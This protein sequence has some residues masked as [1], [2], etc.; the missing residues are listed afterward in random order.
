MGH[1]PYKYFTRQQ[2][3]KEELLQKKSIICEKV[4]IYI[5]RE[6][7]NISYIFCNYTKFINKNNY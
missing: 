2:N 6:I 4:F 7:K 1:S 5:L 3:K